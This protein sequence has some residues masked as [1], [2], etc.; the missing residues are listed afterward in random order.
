MDLK[1][2]L[3]SKKEEAVTEATDRLEELQASYGDLDVDL[4]SIEEHIQK[5]ADS[6]D[7]VY[8]LADSKFKELVG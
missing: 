5:I 1:R 8:Q 4:S 3:Q 7:A 6:Y 2:E